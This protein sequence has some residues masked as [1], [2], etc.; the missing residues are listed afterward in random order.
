MVNTSIQGVLLSVSGRSAGQH[1]TG[2]I[3]GCHGHSLLPLTVPLQ[4][5]RMSDTELDLSLSPVKRSQARQGRRAG[6][7]AREARD[8]WLDSGRSKEESSD[9]E[10]LP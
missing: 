10:K 7:E 6:G 8:S 4:A 3:S 9:N 5:H 2:N 1:R